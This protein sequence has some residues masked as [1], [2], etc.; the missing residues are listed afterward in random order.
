METPNY[1]T[2][3]Y[4][5]YKTGNFIESSNRFDE[6]ER[7]ATCHYHR[8]TRTG[9]F[10]AILHLLR[11]RANINC[12]IIVGL[13]VQFRSFVTGSLIGRPQSPPV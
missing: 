5:S 13:I 8:W 4:I 9:Y 6:A 2:Q 3:L 12:I 7:N 1:D 11:L 10:N